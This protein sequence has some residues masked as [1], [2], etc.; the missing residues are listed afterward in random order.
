MAPSTLSQRIALEIERRILVGELEANERLPPVHELSEM[1]GVSRSVVRDAVQTLVARSLL[2]TRQGSGTVVAERTDAPIGEGLIG[3]L[4]RSGL[5]MG[6][7]VDARAALETQLALL[8]VSNGTDSDWDAMD[9]SLAALRSAVDEG[10]WSDAARAHVRFHLDLIRACALPAL[11]LM[12][13]PVEEVIMVSS[14]PPEL[15]KRT[16]WDVDSHDPVVAALRSRDPDAV[17]AAMK[18]HFAYIGTQ[19]FSDFRA[20]PF[21]SAGDIAGYR[22]FIVNDSNEPAGT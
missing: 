2:N 17:L 4:M 11:D 18:A 13:K 6:D 22:E 14:L 16:L 9:A 20:M 21:S 7:V 5:S 1:L 19:D 12:L 8:A 15:G 10:R 3:V